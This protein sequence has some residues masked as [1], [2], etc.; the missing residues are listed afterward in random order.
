[1]L[2]F[3]WF[4]SFQ[5]GVNVSAISCFPDEREI[6]LIPPASFNIVSV[7]PEPKQD[8]ERRA[9]EPNKVTIRIVLES[10]DND[11]QYLHKSIVN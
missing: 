4:V 5:I 7:T 6:L 9:D 1:M 11:F 8:I 10:I 2:M 3:M